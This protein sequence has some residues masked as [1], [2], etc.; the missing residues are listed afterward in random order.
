MIGPGGRLVGHY[1][2]LCDRVRIGPDRVEYDDQLLD[3][4]FFP[5]GR[6]RVLD[7][8]E[9]KQAREDGLID[10]QTADRIG[11]S[12]AEVQRGIHRIMEDFDALLA[13]LGIVAHSG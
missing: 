8:D 5:D 12:A 3:L 4:W 1:V 7:E 10:G 9:L 6:C 2:H 11:T 13:D